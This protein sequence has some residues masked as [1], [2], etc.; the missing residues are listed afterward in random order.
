MR[1]IERVVA[2][3]KLGL[4]TPDQV[5]AWADREMLQCESPSQEVLDLS[6]EGPARCVHKPEFEF[7]AGPIILPYATE[8]A[9][10]SAAADL[11]SDNSLLEF[12]RWCARAA[13]GEELQ[14][15]EVAFGFQVEHLLYHCEDTQGAMQY[16]RVELPKLFPGF[17]A[18]VA[19]FLDVLPN[20]PLHPNGY[21]GLRPPPPSGELK[22]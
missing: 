22:R 4:I 13:M 21:S 8:F 17:A 12:C 6:L 14:L 5:I 16:A 11:S 9:L 1:P 7:P 18:V 20:P 19:S 10:R 3:W 2:L 15:P